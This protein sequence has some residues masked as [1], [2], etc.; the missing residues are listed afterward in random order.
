[1]IYTSTALIMITNI[2]ADA[3]FYS[4]L[5]DTDLIG[6]SDLTDASNALYSLRKGT[7]P[8]VFPTVWLYCCWCIMIT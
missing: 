2:Q 7:L 3:Q 8:N 4:K 5:P 6:F 1:M